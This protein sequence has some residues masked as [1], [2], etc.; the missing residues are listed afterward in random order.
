MPLTRLVE[1]LLFPPGSA[2]LLMLLGLLLLRRPL[3]KG[4][5]GLGLVI[6]YAASTPA[7]SVALLETLQPPPPFAYRPRGVGRRGDRGPGRRA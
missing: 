1:A 4:L 2:L 7:V 5:L 6:L 3:G